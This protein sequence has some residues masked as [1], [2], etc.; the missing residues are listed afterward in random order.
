MVD[1]FHT[2][3]AALNEGGKSFPSDRICLLINL[4]QNTGENLPSFTHYALCKGTYFSHYLP[5]DTSTVAFLVV[6]T[7]EQGPWGD[8]L[9]CVNG[10]WI[11]LSY[12]GRQKRISSVLDTRVGIQSSPFVD[13]NFFSIISKH[14]ICDNFVLKDF[15]QSKSL[16]WSQR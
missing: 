14:I 6:D 2:A 7:G 16:N 12:I 8:T 11:I 3:R 5:T 15:A 4:T 1:I 10:Y 13:Q 9:L